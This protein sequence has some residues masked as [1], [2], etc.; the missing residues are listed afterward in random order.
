MK[1]TMV[2]GALM[3]MA[4]FG[5]AQES[6]QDV[7]ASVIGVL[8]PQ[9]N[10]NAVQLNTTKTVG[11]LGSYRYM[12]TP[13]SALE[14]NY[15]FAQYSS[16][17]NTSFLPNV[18]IHTRQ[19]E[20]TGAYVYSLNFRNFNPFLEGGVGGLIFTPIRDFQT[21]NFDTSQNTSIGALFGGG[22]AY[23]LSPSWDIRAQY[24]GFVV[25]APD[26]GLTNFKTNRWEVVSM[27]AIGM[28]YHF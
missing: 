19:Q 11:F 17:Y 7:S 27:P 5:Y 1:K 4:S 13:R 25:K 21:T 10:G 28:A 9:V 22:V 6:R 18:R 12:L 23:E 20:I 15:S 14:M 24:R 16:N 2:L 8:T 26:F 3:L